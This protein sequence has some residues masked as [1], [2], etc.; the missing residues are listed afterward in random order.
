MTV[1]SHWHTVAP[2]IIHG[3]GR[4]YPIPDH[5]AANWMRSG[6]ACAHIKYAFCLHP[7]LAQS[8]DLWQYDDYWHEWVNIAKIGEQSLELT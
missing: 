6:S 3:D 1:H 8:V 2:T 7:D 4:C 5:V